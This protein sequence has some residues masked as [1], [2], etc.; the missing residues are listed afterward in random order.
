MPYYECYK[1]KYITSKKNDMKKHLERKIKCPKTIECYSFTDEELFKLSMELNNNNM[2]NSNNTNVC[3]YCNKSFTRNDNLKRHE[4]NICKKKNIHN[5]QNIS[6]TQNTHPNIQTTHT[7]QTINNI[8]HQT[9][10]DNQTNQTNNIIIIN[11]SLKPF[12]EQWTTE[13]IDKYLRQIILFSETKYTDLLDEI[14]KNKE[15]LNVIIEKESNSG[16][17]YKNDNE[18]YVNMKVKQIID[19]SMQKLYEQLNSFYSN[20]I[21]NQIPYKIN[22][23]V[24]ENEK[25]ILDNK[26]ED[27]CNNSNTQNIVSDL[28]SN[29]YEKNKFGAIEM[30]NKILT[31]KIG[32]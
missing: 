19:I 32:Y 8:D 6:N 15:N 20:I 4:N 21:A 12:D 7:T 10:I 2:P 9:I 16:L 28:F 30:S 24:I 1:C 18:L 3:K 17:V 14:L 26:F 22:N 31:K 11:S 27:F 25:K 29:I 13:H 23:D 5:I